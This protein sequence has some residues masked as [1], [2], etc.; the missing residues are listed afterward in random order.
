MNQALRVLSAVLLVLLVPQFTRAQHVH[1][2]GD[3][4]D[5][6]E[7]VP[8]GHDASGHL[9]DGFGHHIDGDGIHTGS[10]GIFENGSIDNHW[11]NN[12]PIYNPYPSNPYYPSGT[13]VNPGTVVYPSGS[14][15]ISGQIPSSSGVIISQPSTISSGTVI[16]NKIPVGNTIPS[17]QP[18]TSTGV[19]VLNN[20]AATGGAINVVLN[21]QSLTL[22]PGETRQVQIAQQV[23]IKFDNGLGK[24]LAYRLDPGNYDFTVSQ[25]TGWNIVKKKQP[26][27][28]ANAIPSL[29]GNA[30]PV[31]SGY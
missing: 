29:P 24:Q 22:Q 10:M 11:F 3:H 9:V 27:A 23:T 17:V 25:E 30:I 16:S 13:I 2:H 12:Y 1:E 8:H 26:E 20:P 18:A 15:I 5:V 6:H 4:L 21:Q 31:P 19:A 14:T 7:N 28:P